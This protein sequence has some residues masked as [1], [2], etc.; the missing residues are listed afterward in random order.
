MAAATE[1]VLNIGSFF[2]PGAGLAAGG[3][4]LATGAARAGRGGRGGKHLKTAPG[5]TDVVTPGG[6]SLSGEN[7][8]VFTGGS[9]VSQGRTDSV[10]DVE[11]D[12]SPVPVRSGDGTAP[13]HD[14]ADR[15]APGARTEGV[16]PVE[17]PRQKSA[18]GSGPTGEG[19]DPAASGRSTENRAREGTEEAAAGT[20]EPR[21]DAAGS[22]DPIHSERSDAD[23]AVTDQRASTDPRAGS[24]A[25]RPENGQTHPLVADGDGQETGTRPPA[26]THTSAS[27][28]GTYDPDA[29]VRQTIPAKGSGHRYKPA[30]VQQALDAAPQNKWGDP[31]DHRNGKPLL[32]ENVNG[33]RGW[34]MRRDPDS[35]EWVAENRGLNE[36]GLAAKGEPGSFGYDEFGDRL[37]YANHRPEYAPGQV[38]AVWRESR[39]EQ[40]RL[41]D[42]GELRLDK[43][44]KESQM[45]VRVRDTSTDANLVSLDGKGKWKL[46]EWEP[47]QSRRNLWD[48]GHTPEA[49]YSQLRTDYL[50]GNISKKSFL[51]RYRDV[52]N[53]GVEDWSRNRSHD[54]E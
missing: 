4:K 2:I 19:G 44:K 54:D 34:I 28:P 46:I 1:S 35:G 7:S 43:P 38:E 24:E 26:G 33:D 53:Y 42:S 10:G 8:T 13:D 14:G 31:V 5:G 36:R 21:Q 45:W 22:S 51:A 16:Q 6:K 48:M 23:L 41:I 30:D 50:A 27:H 11:L 12:T 47:G 18:S 3:G 49:K 32:L 25:A 17:S 29:P 15:D 37:P 52:D 39:D 20:A 40:M 9:K